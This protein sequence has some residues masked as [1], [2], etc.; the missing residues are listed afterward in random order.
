VLPHACGER[1]FLKRTYAALIRAAERR[2]D[3]KSPRSSAVS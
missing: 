2:R 3:A 1:A